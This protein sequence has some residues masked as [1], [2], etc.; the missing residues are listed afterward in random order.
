M[1]GLDDPVGLF[2]PWRFYDSM[3]LLQRH[4]AYLMLKKQAVLSA[5][6][7]TAEEQ[8]PNFWSNRLLS[9]LNIFHKTAHSHLIK[10]LIEG[11][12]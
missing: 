12:I 1:V 2:Q 7:Y 4:V 10:L 3:L 9:A 11:A 5:F 6:S 8:S